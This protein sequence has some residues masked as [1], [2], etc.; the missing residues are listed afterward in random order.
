M[1]TLKDYNSY[2]ERDIQRLNELIEKVRKYQ[3]E[4]FDHVQ[5]VVQTNF[6]H[7]V[8]LERRTNWSTK[9]VEYYLSVEERPVLE[10]KQINGQWVYG[11]Y[12]ENHHFKGTERHIALKKAGELAEKYHCSI[13]RKGF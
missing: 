13:E 9:K 4:L 5:E 12:K 3:K 1:K 2:C 8:K 7:V 10:K 11:T 6:K